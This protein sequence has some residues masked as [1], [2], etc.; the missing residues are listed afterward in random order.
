MDGMSSAR[1]QVPALHQPR[2]A[3]R[4][5]A[6]HTKEGGVARFSQ[7]TTCPLV[8]SVQRT[9]SLSRPAQQPTTAI[10]RPATVSSRHEIFSSHATSDRRSK[11]TSQPRREPS[12]SM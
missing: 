1:H 5:S 10:S 7:R 4:R 9:R 11:I 6:V 2:L 12:V 8:V 3:G